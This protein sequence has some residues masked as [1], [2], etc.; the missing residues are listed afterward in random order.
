MTNTLI[1]TKPITINSPDDRVILVEVFG[2]L[3]EANVDKVAQE[4]Y[5][6]LKN[7]MEGTSFIFDFHE[8][9][10]INS[11]GIGYFLDFYRKISEHRGKM[12]LARLSENVLDILEVVGITKIIGVHFT[13][14]EAKLAIV[15]A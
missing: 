1:K 6:V 9:E 8:V 10:F 11:K 14:D 5:D 13:L 7:S 12:A 4:F 2:H 15:S 3:D